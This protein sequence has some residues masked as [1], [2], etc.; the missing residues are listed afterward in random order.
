MKG[1]D[2]QALVQT[3]AFGVAKT[4]MLGGALRL[5]FETIG[6]DFGWRMP[7]PLQP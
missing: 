1:A 5:F 4:A 7:P 6:A 2:L 3:R